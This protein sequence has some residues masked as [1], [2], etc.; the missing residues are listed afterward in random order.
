LNRDNDTNSS[1]QWKKRTKSK[2]A[3]PGQ[4]EQT[5]GRYESSPIIGKP[6]LCRVCFSSGR[7]LPNKARPGSILC[8]EHLQMQN[9]RMTQSGAAISPSLGPGGGYAYSGFAQHQ[10]TKSTLPRETPDRKFLTQ[11]KILVYLS[12]LSFFAELTFF[13]LFL[14]NYAVAALQNSN[15]FFPGSP[16][17]NA[18][19]SAGGFLAP[20]IDRGW[21]TLGIWTTVNVDFMLSAII[22]YLRD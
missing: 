15:L 17:S 5:Y 20:L 8:E 16:V 18:Y 14:D 11:A 4:Q 21:I 9:S 19:A 3:A 10:L 6:S 12:V 1:L 2:R 13:L 22:M 7:R